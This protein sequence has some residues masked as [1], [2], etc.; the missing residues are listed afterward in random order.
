MSLPDFKK[1]TGDAIERHSKAARQRGITGAGFESVLTVT[2]RYYEF[3]KIGR[4]RKQYPPFVKTK[5]GW[6][7][8]AGGAGVDYAG[9][10]NVITKIV[11]MDYEFI[12]APLGTRDSFL[13]LVAFDA[14][15]QDV[16]HSTYKHDP[17]KQHQLIDLRD[18]ADAGVSAFLLIYAPKVIRVFMLPI[19]NHFDDLLSGRGVKLYELAPDRRTVLPLVPSIAPPAQAAGF[20]IS[21]YDWIPLLKWCPGGHD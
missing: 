14:K 12:G 9:H 7:P 17:K 1:M 3:R 11:P 8:R 4:I 20:P 6:Q 5:T 19:R 13:I 2:H 16:E 21:S 15:V 10:V 18:E